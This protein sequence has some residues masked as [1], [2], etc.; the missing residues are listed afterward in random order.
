MPKT[1]KS[2]RKDSAE[3][4]ESDVSTQADKS[5]RAEIQESDNSYI[6]PAVMG[7]EW[8]GHTNGSFPNK[9]AKLESISDESLELA[10][11]KKPRKHFRNE[12]ERE[13]FVRQYQMKKKTEMCRNWEIS[14]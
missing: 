5:D 4:Y 2:H 11:L 13:N 3:D 7:K 1:K 12:Q 14:G 8:K 10:T 9:N 6:K